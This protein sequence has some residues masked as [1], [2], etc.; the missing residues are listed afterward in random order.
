MIKFNYPDNSTFL[1]EYYAIFNFSD[2]E[3]K[4]WRQF[5]NSKPIINSYLPKTLKELVICQPWQIVRIFKRFIKTNYSDKEL[6]TISFIK[7]DNYYDK[8]IKFYLEHRDQLD[9]STCCYCNLSYINIYKNELNKELLEILN[10][11][12]DE[13]IISLFARVN[14][15]CSP[16]ILKKIKDKQPFTAI[17]DFDNL[18]KRWKGKK[19]QKLGKDI[20]RHQFDI[21]HFLP[22]KDCF[23]LS[24]SLNNF[25]PSCQVCNSRIKLANYITKANQNKLQ[26]R[27]F[28][29]SKNYNYEKELE[30]SLWF[31]KLPGIEFSEHP[32]Y[33]SLYL[34]ENQKD[35]IYM[36][37]AK[38]FRIEDRYQYHICEVLKYIDN[39]RFFNKF[40]SMMMSNNLS[41]DNYKDLGILQEIISEVDFKNDN[42]RIMKKLFNDMHNLFNS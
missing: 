34:D 5:I 13:E 41:E 4:K 31:K 42:N 30:F 21:D 28:P 10:S 22:K 2:D 3:E 40:Y 8:I 1:D 12:Y 35:S 9:I 16:Q 6:N 7:Y 23:L 33:C 37:E 20:V 36:E 17:S 14:E 27:Q 15:N 18:Y 24:L 38:L 19:S 26:E 32:E 39:Q 11:P 25:V 29:T